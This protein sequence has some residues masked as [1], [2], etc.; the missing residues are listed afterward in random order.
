MESAKRK[1]NFFTS[2]TVFSGDL[3]LKEENNHTLDLLN[4][5]DLYWKKFADKPLDHSF[6]LNQATM[7]IKGGKK[8]A[9]I[10][11]LNLLLGDI[12][13]FTDEFIDTVHHFEK[14][15]AA[16]S[17]C[18]NSVNPI[19]TRIVTRRQNDS[20]YII[21]GLF[22]G[23]FKNKCTSRFLPIM[24]ATVKGMTKNDEGWECK[25]IVD[26]KFVGLGTRYIEACSF[27][28]H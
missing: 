27:N 9:N 4:R 17:D 14:R 16:D 13:F 20:F 24:E 3:D 18:S 10:T 19:T 15:E 28:I 2:S 26:N 11:Q 22:T 7:T 23:L 6:Q 1:V 5:A 21:T 12:I 25:T 8:M